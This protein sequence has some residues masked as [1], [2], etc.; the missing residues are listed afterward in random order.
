MS[1]NL[2][3][4]ARVDTNL[5]DFLHELR[6]CLETLLDRPPLIFPHGTFLFLE[7]SSFGDVESAPAGI[8][9]SDLNGLGQDDIEN[10]SLYLL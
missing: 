1:K 6:I 4:P 8:T 7:R 2:G 10:T 3:N 9:Q 5:F